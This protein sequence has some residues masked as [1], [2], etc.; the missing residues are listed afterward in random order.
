MSEI[1]AIGLTNS[2]PRPRESNLFLLCGHSNLLGEYFNQ[3]Q[4]PI[5]SEPSRG[6]L[7]SEYCPSPQPLCLFSKVFSKFARR[8]VNFASV[9]SDQLLLEWSMKFVVYFFICNT[10]STFL[11]I[12]CVGD[13]VVLED[14]VELLDNTLVN[15]YKLSSVTR[16]F[17]NCSM[18]R[19][20]NTLIKKRYSLLW[21]LYSWSHLAALFYKLFY[22]RIVPLSSSFVRK[23]WTNYCF[24]WMRY[25]NYNVI[26]FLTCRSK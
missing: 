17:E 23:Y 18:Y 11:D 6:I 24:F 25:G 16:L 10:Y 8:R 14:F 3:A 21:Y 1:F 13:C 22:P 26:L 15:S 9:F 7:L 2:E 5:V 4:V 19:Y 12:R 20:P